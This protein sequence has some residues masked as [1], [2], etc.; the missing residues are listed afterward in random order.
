MNTAKIKIQR[1]NP[2]SLSKQM[3]DINV[4]KAGIKIMSQKGEILAFKISDLSRTQALILKQEALSF[5]LEFA[6]PR[7]LILCADKKYEGILFGKKNELKDMLKGLKNQPF[8]LPKIADEILQ[9]VQ[10]SQVFERQI[11]GIVNCTDNSFYANSRK[12]ELEAIKQ[13]EEFIGSSVHIIDI[14]AASSRPGADLI[15]PKE[16]LAKLDGIFKHIVKNNLQ[17]SSIFSIDTYNALTA[18][19]ALDAGFV[20]INDVSGLSDFKMAELCVKYDSS[21]VLMHTKGRPKDMSNNCDY[22]HLF[23]EMDA[24]FSAKIEQL[25]QAFVRKI[26]IDPG[27]GFAKN[28]FQNMQILKHLEHFK[29]FNLPILMGLSRKS[30]LQKIIDKDAF[31]A[32][33]I[34]LG[35]NLL[36]LLNGAN[37]L[38]VHDPKEHL[39]LL[40]LLKDYENA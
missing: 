8:S 23:S 15:E 36:A 14:G 4:D 28:P 19:A 1:L 32:L 25:K 5:N 20:M 9:N 27:F 16:E 2:L 18:Q 34:T 3:Q 38:R 10:S 35:A 40:R 37:I 30:T 13:I 31:G 22:L 39:D 12:N 26:I 17:K 21:Y 29:K 11:M 6:T 24:F 33:S 7:D